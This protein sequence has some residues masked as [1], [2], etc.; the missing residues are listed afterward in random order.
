MARVSASAVNRTDL[1]L[2]LRPLLDKARL[3]ESDSLWAGK[4]VEP[5]WVDP[6]Y[7]T[8][9]LAVASKAYLLELRSIYIVGHSRKHIDPSRFVFRDVPD[10]DPCFHNRTISR[11]FIVSFSDDISILIYTVD[12]SVDQPPWI[13]V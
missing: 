5:D 13:S 6:N 8:R 10:P 2:R 3:E 9:I 1:G 7:L 11:Q 12:C 4:L